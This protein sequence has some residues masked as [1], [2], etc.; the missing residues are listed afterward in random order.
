MSVCI[1][2]AE[3]TV[4]SHHRSPSCPAQGGSSGLNWTHLRPTPGPSS[5]L[6]SKL[7]LGCLALLSRWACDALVVK[8]GPS[9]GT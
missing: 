3:P 9:L 4:K 6:P 2:V 5:G 7:A 1:G 8:D